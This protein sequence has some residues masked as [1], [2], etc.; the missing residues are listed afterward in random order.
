MLIDVRPEVAHA[1]SRELAE[2]LLH[3]AEQRMQAV[4]RGP[5]IFGNEFR[6]GALGQRSDLP[7]R[8]VHIG[9]K[10][11][12]AMPAATATSKTTRI[13]TNGA[14]VSKPPSATYSPTKRVARAGA[15]PSRPRAVTPAGRHRYPSS[16]RASLKPLPPMARSIVGGVAESLADTGEMSYRNSTRAWRPRMDWAAHEASPR[17]VGVARSVVR[18]DLSKL[19]FYARSSMSRSAS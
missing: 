19:R 13:A 6:D 18:C 7:T 1:R 8:H 14:V 9:V 11:S 3:L 16:Y 12:P 10:I 2:P 15:L 5:R 4:D 17:S